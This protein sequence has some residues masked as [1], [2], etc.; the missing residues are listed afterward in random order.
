MNTKIKT[1]IVNYNRLELPR[2]MAEWLNDRGCDVIFIDNNSTYEPLLD[3]YHRSGFPVY[4][5]SKNCGHTVVWH[6]DI[7]D[8]LNVREQ[9]IVTDPDLDLSD[10]PHDFINILQRGLDRHPDVDKCALSL[11]ID[12]LPDTPEGNFI[13]AHESKYWKR[14]SP[15]DYY[16]AD[17]D[18]TLALYRTGVDW[19]SHSAVRT[20]LPY[21]ARHVPWYYSD[22]NALTPDEQFYF[23]SADGSSS[24]KKRLFPNI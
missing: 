20:P 19:Y 1:F 7:L 22:F 10:V 3:W 14:K 18:T 21:V 15:F 2:Q 4:Q 16:I 24:G 13:R 5:L 9:Y 11:R 6:N 12:D 17:T 8:L 23:R